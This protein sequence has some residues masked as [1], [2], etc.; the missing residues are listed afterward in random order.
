MAGRPRRRARAM[1]ANGAW[2]GGFTATGEHRSGYE[3]LD[4]PELVRRLVPWLKRR[5]RLD[6]KWQRGSVW[7]T[8]AERVTENWTMESVRKRLK[9]QRAVVARYSEPGFEHPSMVRHAEERIAKLIEATKLLNMAPDSTVYRYG[10][11]VYRSAKAA[12]EAFVQNVGRDGAAQALALAETG[13]TRPAEFGDK[14]A[15][16]NRGRRRR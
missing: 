14:P 16:S 4:V 13:Y 10:Y 15:Y 5:G 3:D 2:P 6:D 9:E 11:E 7:A 8:T 12:V 1:L